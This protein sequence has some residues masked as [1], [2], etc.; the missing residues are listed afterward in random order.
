[1]EP[2]EPYTTGELAAVLAVPKQVIRKLLNVLTAEEHIRRKEPESDR[3]IWI[4]EPPANSCPDCGHK[5]EVKFLHSVLS[6]AQY[7]PR[8][9]TQ[10]D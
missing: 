8:C 2:F 7:C 6:A 3:V 10:L 1:M 9:G 4:R 5:F